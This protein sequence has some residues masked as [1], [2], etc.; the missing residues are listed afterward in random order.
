M[1]S[2]RRAGSAGSAGAR[3]TT[4]PY[5]SRAA[6]VRVTCSSS[7]SARSSELTVMTLDI[8]KPP[9]LRRWTRSTWPFA[10]DSLSMCSGSG[11]ESCGSG[12]MNDRCPPE[13]LTTPLVWTSF[14]PGTVFMS[15]LLRSR[16]P[17]TRA[18][19]IT[20]THPPPPNSLPPGGSRGT[21][22]ARE[23]SEPCQEQKQREH[24]QA[25]DARRAERRRGRRLGRRPRRRRQR[26]APR[27]PTW[28]PTPASRPAFR[29]GRVRPAAARSSPARCTP[30]PPP[31]RAP[32]RPRTPGSARRPSAC[33][34]TPPTR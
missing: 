28:S 17:P 6:E 26:P 1:C 31:S 22:I 24:H 14:L 18:V 13:V 21:C 20:R 8:R 29:A 27:P 32:R 16:P 5:A 2:R 12:Q 10:V 11:A 34:P 33:S 25:P 30:A 7:G 23:S 3:A 9:P 4:W 15:S 19:R